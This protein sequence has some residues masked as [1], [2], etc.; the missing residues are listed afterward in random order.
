MNEEQKKLKN[1]VKLLAKATNKTVK[2]IEDAIA[3]DEATAAFAFEDEYELGQNEANEANKKAIAKALK[4]NGIALP[5]WENF[6]QVVKAVLSKV[7][8][9]DDDDDDD[10]DPNSP[11]LTQAD[12]D[13]LVK[14]HKKEIAKI[15]SAHEAKLAEAVEAAKSESEAGL[16]ILERTSLL[17]DYLKEH[18]YSIP[19]DPKQAARRLKFAQSEIEGLKWVKDEATGDYVKANE[20][21]EPIREKG[22]LVTLK[23]YS[24]AVF[25][26]SH[27]KSAANH[28]DGNNIPQPDPNQQASTFKFEKFN[29]TPP[30]DA[31]EYNDFVT[32]PAIPHEQKLEVR[33][34]WKTTQAKPAEQQAA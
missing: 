31:K 1:A 9:S 25:E 12:F 24:N 4:K 6:D 20:D 17:K 28:K 22:K 8:V 27:T 33:E 34:F 13:K 2:E 29:G 15:N 21:G 30:K 5:D 26:A 10:A 3:T 18:G 19:A 7:P 11:K 14:A 32:N 23:E 16:S